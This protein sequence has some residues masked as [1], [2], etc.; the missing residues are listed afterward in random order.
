MCLIWPYLIYNLLVWFWKVLVLFFKAFSYYLYYILSFCH[1]IIVFFNFNF[2]TYSFCRC[3]VISMACILFWGLL[4]MFYKVTCNS[5][6]HTEMLCI[7]QYHN[8]NVNASQLLILVPW[9]P[10]N[11]TIVYLNAITELVNTTD[12]CSL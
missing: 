3:N 4:I 5:A 2:G 6:W 12:L 10:L 9:L 1:C 7:Y 11:T 8:R